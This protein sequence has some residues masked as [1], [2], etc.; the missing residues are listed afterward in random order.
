MNPSLILLNALVNNHKFVDWDWIISLQEALKTTAQIPES[1]P[2][3][4]NANWSDRLCEVVVAFFDQD[5]V[6][7]WIRCA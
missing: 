4:L 3:S 2:I 5:Q 6:G 1:L 7:L